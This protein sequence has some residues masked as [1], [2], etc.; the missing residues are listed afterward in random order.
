[1][2]V[3]QIRTNPLAL[4]TMRPSDLLALVVPLLAPGGLVATSGEALD[5]VQLSRLGLTFG[6]ALWCVSGRLGAGR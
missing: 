4:L 6:T 2:A 3:P 5:A 1:M